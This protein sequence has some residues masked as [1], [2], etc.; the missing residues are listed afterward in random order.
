[1]PRS[2][3]ICLSDTPWYHIVSRCVRRAYLC[4][5]DYASG[6]NFEHRRGWIEKRIRELAG[7]F[8]IDVA[9]FAVMSNHYHIVVRVDQE[10]ALAWDDA[11]VLRRWTQ[12]FSGAEVVQC[13][14]SENGDHL[15]E[16]DLAKVGEWV[17]TYRQRLFD[18][19]WF[20][21]ILNES[22]ARMANVEDGITGRFWEGRFKSQAL[23]DEQSLLAAMA[24]VD[25]NPVRA[26]MAATPEQSAH[27]S[28]KLRV[29]EL[30][31]VAT[32]QKSPPKKIVK[33]S[34]SAHCADDC[35]ALLADMLSTGPREL[36]LAP[37]LPFNPDERR[38][39]AIPFA[40]ADY[41]AL[42]DS[43][44]RVVHPDK[45][46]AIPAETPVLLTRLGIDA[47][48]FVAFANSFFQQFGHVVGTP[49]KL[50][51]LASI[52]QSRNPRGI[53]TARSLFERS[54]A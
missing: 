48:S 51:Q 54:V 36:S 20:M 12:L 39:A 38:A 29:E 33:T 27:T 50:K 30:T 52:R 53:A 40:F 46:G 2:N 5:E 35:P 14:L 6:Q 23:L 4:G 10:Q 15:G 28:V 34:L 3:Q 8:A 47:A 19:S 49:E 24:Y 26:G 25:L 42:L 45:R 11:E 16:V 17:E 41:L 13:Y 37:H 1:M 22:L 7:V 32:L 44:G 18:I 21:R 31:A 9:A 43:V